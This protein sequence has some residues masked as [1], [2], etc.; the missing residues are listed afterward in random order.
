MQ[1][2]V[3][4]FRVQLRQNS[5]LEGYHNG[6]QPETDRP[7]LGKPESLRLLDRQ[8]PAENRYLP[9]SRCGNRWRIPRKSD[10]PQHLR[11]DTV[12]LLMNTVELFA[13]IGGFRVAADTIP[14]KTLWANDICPKACAVYRRRFGAAELHE[15][16]I[17]GLAD[18][19]PDHDLLTG[20]FPCQPFSSAGKK[21]GIRDPRG[22]LL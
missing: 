20:G 21:N 7:L 17:V 13:G 8:R 3:L 22:T 12:R 16:D 1:C 14:L 10:Y 5:A 9:N 19:I 4:S 6:T 15:G 11:S 2:R 18:T